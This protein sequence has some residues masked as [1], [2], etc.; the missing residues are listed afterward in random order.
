MKER[1]SASL[2][3]SCDSYFVWPAPAKPFVFNSL[4]FLFSFSPFFGICN[5]GWSNGNEKCYA[6]CRQIHIFR[7]EIITYSTKYSNFTLFSSLFLF[8]RTLSRCFDSLEVLLHLHLHLAYCAVWVRV[9]VWECERD[10]S[11]HAISWAKRNFSITAEFDRQTDRQSSNT[12]ANT[13]LRATTVKPN[14]AKNIETT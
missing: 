7:Y 11:G 4:I 12:R 14:G 5:I 10:R 6:V 9:C 3:L 2:L 8:Q 1:G 13:F